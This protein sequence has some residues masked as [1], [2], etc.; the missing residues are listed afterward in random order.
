MMST[1]SI[2]KADG[3]MSSV[4]VRF[5][6][7]TWFMNMM[8]E[9]AIQYSQSIRLEGGKVGE[10]HACH[11]IFVVYCSVRRRERKDHACAVGR[12]VRRVGSCM[13]LFK[14]HVWTPAKLPCLSLGYQ[15]PYVLTVSKHTDLC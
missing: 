2:S 15:N 11:V 5:Y 13:R 9:G 8:R 12:K 1:W 4:Y 3:Q 10:D 14:V 6:V 7:G